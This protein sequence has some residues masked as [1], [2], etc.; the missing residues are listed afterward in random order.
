MPFL[1]F[2]NRKQ[3]LLRLRQPIFTAL[4]YSMKL[5]TAEYAIEEKGI[6]DENVLLDQEGY[7]SFMTAQNTK[8]TT[9]DGSP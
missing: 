5:Q 8:G 2:M 4:G 6:P 7:N 9:G 1:S 3:T